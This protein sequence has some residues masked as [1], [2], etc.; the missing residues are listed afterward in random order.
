MKK[1]FM[2]VEAGERKIQGPVAFNSGGLNILRGQKMT[3]KERNANFRQSSQAAAGGNVV[4]GRARL[5]TTT[6]VRNTT[7]G[8]KN[9]KTTRKNTRIK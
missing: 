2:T 7:T 4:D 3:N 5:N 6:P 9:T 8:G 1:M